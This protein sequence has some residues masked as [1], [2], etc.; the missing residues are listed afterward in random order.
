[1]KRI[2]L[3]WI[4][5]T[6]TAALTVAC[7][8]YDASLLKYS[9]DTDAAADATHDVVSEPDATAAED[10][11]PAPPDVVEE[12]LADAEAEAAAC[13][14]C[15]EQGLV[16][17]PCA[18]TGSDPATELDPIVYAVHT[19]RV[20]LSPKKPD[21]WR[22]I[23]LDMDC[24]LTGVGGTPSM[25]VGS[26]SSAAVLEDG[27]LGRDNSFGRNVGGMIRLLSQVGALPYDLEEI[28]NYYFSTGRQGML[29]EVRHYSG[30]ADDPRV[31]LAL[32]ASA[33]TRD[34]ITHAAVTPKWDG[35]DE[36]SI[37]QTSLA[38]GNQPLFVDDSAY[39]SGNVLV[40]HM[41][42][43]L[44]LTFTADGSLFEMALA[45]S[46]LALELSA[47]RQRVTLGTVNGTWYRTQA[48]AAVDAYMAQA[49]LCS[50]NPIYVQ[51][52]KV[53]ENAADIR[54]DLQAAPQLPCNA[55]SVGIELSAD[56]A[57]LGQAEAPPPPKPSQCGDA[58]AADAGAD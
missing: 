11:D 18:P 23:G 31:W 40:A 57:T 27:L 35:T 42:E 52:K 29:F 2:A 50:D 34:P 6:A 58:G 45:R 43:G 47:D 13:D 26:G 15:A 5:G 28:W 38:P 20:G 10:V 41:P 44:P 32:Y 7:S 1:M 49:G 48:L 39:V 25:C 8:V 55:V 17:P 53:I 54:A 14:P 51:G 9:T 3:A 22:T 36:W 16:R 30:E 19:L 56:R 37:L 24:L 4:I 46:V 12:A 33:G 21:D